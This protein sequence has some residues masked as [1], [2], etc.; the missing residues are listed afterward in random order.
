MADSSGDT[1]E[2]LIAEAE[3][4][5]FSGWD[6]SYLRGRMREETPSWDYAGLVRRHLSAAPSLLDLGTGGG[7]FLSSLTPLPAVVAATEAHAPNVEIARAR[8]TPLGITVVAV[9]GAPHNLA[10]APGTGVGTL[11]FPDDS[12]ALVIDRH[13]SYYPAEVY[14]ILQQEGIFLT[15]QVG[16]EHHQ[17][18]NTLLGA[19][20][21]DSPQWNLDFAVRQVEQAGLRVVEAREEFPETF[22]SDIG[23]IVYY[24]KAVP[25]QIPDFTV[26]RYRERLAPL[27]ERITAEGGVRVQ[28]HLFYLEAVKP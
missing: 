9:D 12:F 17:G 18:L 21:S 4:Q 24:L 5:P 8:L 23:A 7:E 2:R 26:A 13:E 6:F 1:F 22:F 27:H 19:P 15:Q 3:R 11:P 10:I 14:R 25:W 20:R 16:G 28:G